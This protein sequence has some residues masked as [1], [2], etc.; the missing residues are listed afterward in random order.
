M[1]IKSFIDH[2]KM[3]GI[4]KYIGVPDSTLSDFCKAL[5]EEDE[6]GLTYTV[7]VNEGSA[8]AIAIGDYLSTKKVSCVFM[9]NS[10]IGNMLNP[11][12]SIANSAIYSI[13]ILFVIGWRGEYAFQDEPQHAFQGKITLELLKTL[14]VDYSILDRNTTEGDFEEYISIAMECLKNGKQYAFIVRPGTFYSYKKYLEYENHFEISRFEAIKKIIDSLDDSSLIISTTGKISREFM[15][16]KGDLSNSFLCVGG[17]GYASAISLGIA[18]NAKTKKVFCLDGDGSSLMHMGNIAFIGNSGIPN[19]YHFVLNNL[20]HESVGGLPTNMEKVAFS[21]IATACNYKKTFYV[22]Y[23]SEL[24]DVLANIKMMEGP[25]MIEIGVKNESCEE[26]PR[27]ED[28]NHLKKEFMTS[29][30]D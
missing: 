19:V 26:L 27:P 11:L 9:Q 5:N 15:K 24:E 6:K 17:M 12:A 10:G 20:A 1:N 22:R 14:D 7:A 23:M 29:L 8:T 30:V 16:V 25:V 2:L 21:K 28:L 13:P 4:S 3:L 18:R